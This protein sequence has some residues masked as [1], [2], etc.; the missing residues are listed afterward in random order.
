MIKAKLKMSAR[1]LDKEE[2]NTDMLH[3]TPKVP[4]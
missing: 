2:N 4:G 3:K 1:Y